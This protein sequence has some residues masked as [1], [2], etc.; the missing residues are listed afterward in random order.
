MADWNEILDT[1][2]EPDAPLTAVLAG[3]WRDNH[4]AVIEGS[5]GA[6]KISHRA[7]AD[8]GLIVTVT[9]TSEIFDLEPVKVLRIYGA[10]RRVTAS[11]GGTRIEFSNNNGSTWVNPVTIANPSGVP[12]FTIV[13]GYIDLDTGVFSRLSYSEDFIPQF[14][15]STLTVPSGVNAFRVSNLGAGTV[16]SYGVFVVAGRQNF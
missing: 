11:A 4:L 9:D 1:Q 8:S 14:V 3:Q 5:T 15:T 16:H 6:P 12:G 7:M 2:I 13:D 10:S